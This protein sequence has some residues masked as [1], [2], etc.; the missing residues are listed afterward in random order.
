MLRPGLRVPVAIAHDIVAVGLAWLLAYGLRFNFDIPEVFWQAALYSL[1]WLVPLYAA[2]LPQFGLYRGIWRFASLDDLQ[3]IVLAVAAGAVLAAAIKLMFRV[4]Y[5]PRS[6]L[7][8]H[9]L[10]LLVVMGGSRFA[11]RSWKELHL[12]GGTR[13]VGTPALLVASADT[14]IGVLRDLSRSAEWQVVGIIDENP[15]RRGAVIE[16]VR[17]LGSV[18]E[19][20]AWSRRLEV[21]HVIVALPESSAAQRRQAVEAVNA[22]GLAPLMLPTVEDLLCGRAASGAVR[23]VELEDLLG[24]EPVTLDTEGLRGFLQ[25]QVVMVTGAGGSIGAELCRQIARFGPRLLVLFELNEF[26]LYRIAEEFRER[27]PHTPIA[28]MIGDV[29][30]ARRVAEAMQRHAPAVVFHAAAFKHVPLMEESNAWEALQ[31]NVLGTWVVAG[32]AAAAGVRT[33]V[34]ISTDKAVN[35]T[36]VMGASKRLAEMVCQAMQA[37]TAT[38]FEM[39]RFGN[40]L[41]SAGS[42]IPKFRSQIA[43]GG[44]VTVTHPDMVRYFMSIPEA[45]QLVLQA[46]CM[47]RGGEIFVMDMGEPVRIV[48]LARDMIRLSGLTEQQVRIEFSGLRPGEKL[49][50][51]LLTDDEHTRPTPHRKLRIARA[52]EVDPGWLEALLRWLRQERA[53]DDAEVRRELKR[54]VPEYGPIGAPELRAIPGGRADAA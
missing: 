7:L 27:L 29:R 30:N 2:L 19:M 31:N 51:E 28:S 36:S 52:R 47:G 8:I 13:L 5:V 11:Y 50:E 42:V 18:E 20:A 35:P 17:V 37:H 49:F 53:P 45:A 39:V 43:R 9:P 41:G 48:D 10:L 54:W 1:L 38:R 46:G 3:R 21:K 23:R 26:N 25:G 16:R 44:P 4:P 12:Y 40:V 33:F 22:A 15:K 14:A 6:V 24:R 34:F 32:E